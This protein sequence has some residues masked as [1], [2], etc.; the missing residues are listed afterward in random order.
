[1]I[2]ELTMSVRLQLPEGS[3]SMDMT[4]GRG[5]VLPNGDFVKAFCV[6]EKNDTSDLTYDEAVKLGC[7]VTDI[8]TDVEIAEEQAQ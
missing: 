3:A 2:V 5:W 8:V 1:M 4:G 7:D 6:L